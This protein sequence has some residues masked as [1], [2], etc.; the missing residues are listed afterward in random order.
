MPWPR[1]RYTRQSAGTTYKNSTT[2]PTIPRHPQAPCL[3]LQTYFFALLFLSNAGTL[4]VSW[5]AFKKEGRL[6]RT[7]IKHRSR[8][9]GGVP[10]EASLF[11]SEKSPSSKALSVTVENCL[12]GIGLFAGEISKSD[13]RWFRRRGC[14]LGE[15]TRNSALSEAMAAV[16]LV[17]IGEPCSDRTLAGRTSGREIQR[18]DLDFQWGGK[19]VLKLQH[20]QSRGLTSCN[21]WL[22]LHSPRPGRNLGHLP[23]RNSKRRHNC[24]STI[25]TFTMGAPG[26]CQTEKAVALEQERSAVRKGSTRAESRATRVLWC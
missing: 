9:V 7:A 23:K 14:A 26:L 4:P 18:T 17:T 22:R 15:A 11:E 8:N 13:V 21:M 20:H 3:F 12:S 1:M 2:K 25:Q 16:R 5:S 24:G 19:K 6:L 10:N